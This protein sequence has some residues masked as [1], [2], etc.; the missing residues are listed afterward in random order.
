MGNENGNGSAG[1][2]LH[3]DSKPISKP[4]AEEF[5][6]AEILDRVSRFIRSFVHLSDEQA[7]IVTLWAAHTHSF[8]SA[9]CTPYLSIN[10][11]T[12]GSGKTRLLESLELIVAK[13]WLTGKASAA[14]LIR[15]IDQQ[16]PSLLL[17]ESDAAF[18]GGEEYAEV[19]RGVLNSG[20]YSDGVA[21]CCV[22]Q[23]SAIT[24]KDFKVFCPKAIAGIGNSLPDTVFDRCIPIRLQKKRPGETVSRFRKYR[25]KE[26]AVG[27]KMELS[28]WQSS[29]L[30]QLR[31]VEPQLPDELTDRQQDILEPLLAIAD[32]A[33]GAWPDAARAAAVKI[34]GSSA[35]ADEAIHIKLLADIR[36]VFEADKMASAELI[37][38]LKAIETS[39]W[40]DWSKGKGLTVNGLSRLLK[41]FEIAPRTVRLEDKT[42]KGYLRE[43]FVD[44]WDR[45]LAVVT[46]QTGFQTVTPSQSASLLSEND[47][48][49]DVTKSTVTLQKSAPDPHKHCIVTAVTVQKPLSGSLPTNGAEINS[50]STCPVCGSYAVDSRRNPVHCFTCELKQNGLF[51]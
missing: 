47:F 16:R 46:S 43:S 24:V 45:Y 2:V 21:S 25:A 28:R 33:C 40:A 48:S 37:E 6:G 7:R 29:L 3:F 10:S 11:A 17:D 51:H 8:L 30:E 20:F 49:T 39:P 22:G 14:A 9:T 18:N 1:V 13:P 27:I 15:K 42:A 35:A 41:P 36:E 44:A 12:K 32:L 34:F 38:K 5:D 23:G 19:L 4:A 31:H 26:V 50:M